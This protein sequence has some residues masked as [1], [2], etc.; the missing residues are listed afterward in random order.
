MKIFQNNFSFVIKFVSDVRSRMEILTKE[1]LVRRK[2]A[3]V[4]ISRAF[5][6][7]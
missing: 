2:T 3:P 7:Y 5:T 6:P 4:A 1:N